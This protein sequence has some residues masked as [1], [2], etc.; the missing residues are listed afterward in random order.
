M[1]VCTQIVSESGRII[2]STDALALKN[3]VARRLSFT[4]RAQGAP[5]DG[6]VTLNSSAPFQFARPVDANNFDAQRET[7]HEID[8]VMGLGSNAS[9]SIFDPQDLFTWSSADV[10]NITSNGTRYFSINGGVTKIVDLNQSAGMDFGDWLSTLCPQAHPYVQNASDC[11]GQSL[12]VAAT[13]PEGIDLDVI[14]YDL[15]NATAFAP[16]DFNGDGKSDI[17]WQNTITGQCVIWMSDGTTVNLPT[18]P[19]SWSIAG[20]GDFNGDGKPDI[21]WQ[22]TITGQRLIWMS[23]G[24]T[25][26]LPTEPTYWSIVAP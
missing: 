5:Y 14:G 6:I 11:P 22:N 8:E 15:V 21:I 13:S 16:S 3:F 20:T 18:E 2:R 17:V 7:E 24:T 9:V 1:R 12:D 10:R 25:V 23:D 19:T 26:N 4:G